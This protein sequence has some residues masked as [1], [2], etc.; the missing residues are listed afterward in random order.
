MDLKSSG[1]ARYAIDP[2]TELFMASVSRDEPDAPIYLWINPKFETAD[3][4]SDSEAEDILAEA[5]IIYAH[6]A[7]FEQTLTW[8]THQRGAAS[9]FKKEPPLSVWRCTAAM[10][11]K[12]GLPYSLEQCAAALGIE[13]Q[14]DTKGKALIRFFSIPDDDGNFNEPRDHPDKWLQFCD[15]C[16]QDTR[17]EKGVGRALKPFELTGAALATFQFDLRMNQRGVPINVPA[18]LNAQ[19]MIDEIQSSVAVEFRAL[20]GINPT[21]R[22]KVRALVGLPNMQAE[23]IEAALVADKFE[24][25][26]TKRVLELYSLLSFAAVKKVRTMLD[27]VCPDGRARGC[28]MYYGAATGRWT[29]RGLQVQNMKRSPKWMKGLTDEVYALIKR[30]CDVENLE[31]IYGD[32]LELIAGVIRHFIDSGEPILDGDF[33]AVEGRVACWIAGQG[34]ILDCWRNGEDLYKRAAAFVEE[35]PEASIQNP[36]PERD[37]GKVVELACQFGLGTDGFILT[38]EKFGIECDEE[39]AK[40]AVHEYYRPTHRKIVD[41]WWYFDDCMVKCVRDPGSRHDPFRTARIA[42]INYLLLRL[43]SGRSLAYPHVQLGMSA[44]VKPVIRLV[45]GVEK[46]IKKGRAPKPEVTYWG[47]LPNSTQWGR[48]KLY[49]SLAFQ[50]EVQAIAA[51]C[52]AHGAMTAEG[53]GMLPF[54]LIHD[55]GL[56]ERGGHTADEYAAALS[57]LPEWAAGLPLKSETHVTEYYRK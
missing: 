22:E 46:I 12:A 33:N 48:V 6:S 24:G 10:A 35:V 25:F 16:V 45:D 21:Q 18:C 7:P 37:F 36:S 57:D 39:K 20:T 30:G 55:Q 54:M 9:P 17:A 56:A 23:T 26:A 8:G 2:S 4:L 41:R 13:Q 42:G 31:L 51:D 15:Y 14:K 38:C 47:Q 52:I 43:P 5:D 34:D 53:L 19:R 50:N 32:P 11:R 29:S 40:R 3:R 44:E 1:A 27:Y 49:G 28:H